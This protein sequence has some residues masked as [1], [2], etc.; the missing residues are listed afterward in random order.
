[1]APAHA[2]GFDRLAIATGFWSYHTSNRSEYNQ[3]NTGV[4]LEYELDPNWTLAAGHY[5]NSVE[6]DSTYA[7]ALW[8]PDVAQAQFGAVR[9]SAGVAVGLVNG[10]PELRDGEVAPTLLPVATLM[11]GPFGV[12]LTYIPSVAGRADGAFALQFKYRFGR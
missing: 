6:R 10:Y 9:L 12:N 2:A 7:Q 8:T 4:G 5:K 1:M 3:T 11:V